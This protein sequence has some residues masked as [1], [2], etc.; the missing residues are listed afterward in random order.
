MKYI[1]LKMRSKTYKI[2]ECDIKKIHL[3]QMKKRPSLPH[4]EDDGEKMY[5]PA[6]TQV[7]DYAFTEEM[8]QTFLA[9]RSNSQQFLI[10]LLF[11]FLIIFYFICQ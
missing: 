10:F 11:F 4:Y 6:M 5:S 1:A 2:A 3:K 7:E 9:W 8:D